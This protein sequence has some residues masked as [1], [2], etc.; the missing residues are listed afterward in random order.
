LIRDCRNGQ[1]TKTFATRR[2]LAAIEFIRDILG[3]SR[4]GAMDK[5]LYVLGPETS[6]L[7]QRWTMYQATPAEDAESAN[8]T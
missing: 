3:Q 1:H 7:L 6:Y 4:T 8:E 5:S 2:L